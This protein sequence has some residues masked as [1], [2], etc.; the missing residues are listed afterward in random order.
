MP[1]SPNSGT[2]AS[3]SEKKEFSQQDL[4]NA[5]A[6]AAEELAKSRQL[7]S[8]LE[9]ENRSLA[10][11]LETA[12]RSSAILKEFNE[13]RK[14]ETEALK[15][16]VAAK[17]ETIAAKDAVIGSQEELVRQLKNKK[18]SPWKRLRDVLIGVAVFAVLK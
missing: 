14:N 18:A 9:V 4:I 5:C 10:D 13:T 3:P 11:R 16:A 8:A 12:N 17:N 1:N 7:A 15:T 2:R 6:A